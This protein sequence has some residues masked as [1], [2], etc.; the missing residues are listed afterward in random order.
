VGKSDP[1]VFE[2]YLKI[3]DAEK[4]PKPKKVGF[5]GFSEENAFTKAFLIDNHDKIFYDMKLNNWQ[6]NDF[7]Y[8][9]DQKFDLIVCTRCAYFCKEPLLMMAEFYRLLNPRGCIFIDW[10]LGDHWRF[11]NF[12]VG[13]VKDGEHEWAYNEDNFLWSA[14]WSD[15]SSPHKEKFSNYIKK[16]NYPSLEEAIFS[17]VPKILYFDDLYFLGYVKSKIYDFTLWP[18]NP[19][20]Y[21]VLVTRKS[22][23]RSPRGVVTFKKNNITFKSK[24]AKHDNLRKDKNRILILG[25]P[26]GGTNNFSSYMHG[27]GENYCL[28]ER[29]KFPYIHSLENYLGILHRD[30]VK[31]YATSSNI[32][33]KNFWSRAEF[34]KPKNL[35]LKEYQHFFNKTPGCSPILSFLH[36]SDKIIIYFRHP[37]LV[38]KSM[39]E[40]IKKNIHNAW[41]LTE[42]PEQSSAKFIENYCSIFSLFKLISA[43]GV[44]IKILFHE[45]FLISPETKAHNIDSIIDICKGSQSTEALLTNR[46]KFHTNNKVDG[47]GGFSFSRKISF[48]DEIRKIDPHIMSSVLEHAEKNN[49]KNELFKKFCNYYLSPIFEAKK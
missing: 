25:M 13:W 47:F 42:Y 46:E 20:L 29:N 11:D 36:P 35:S 27:L 2:T 1:H 30:D 7:P 33:W 32:I 45:D 17:E 15:H 10:G 49:L 9:I 8:N 43:Y 41:K 22:D 37:S 31:K 44:D 14:I 3:L 19:Q 16:F 21:S 38:L 28:N 48:D 34:P 40:L 4:I 23:P 18:E 39:D 12:K 24:P 6:I 5:F 26:R